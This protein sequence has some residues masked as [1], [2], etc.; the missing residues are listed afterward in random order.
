M[1]D[2]TGAIHFTIVD[3]RRLPLPVNTQVL[4][5]LLNGAA[6]IDAKWATGGD[7]KISSIPFKDTGDDAY[8]VFAHANGFSDAV[9]PNRVQ[10]VR[11]G[12]AEVALLAVPTNGHFHFQKWDQFRNVDP[13]I[14]KLITN[15]ATGDPGER[16]SATTESHPM[17][18]GALL[19]LATAIRDIPL[20]DRP[21]PL[22]NFYWEVMWDELAPDRFW[23]WVDVNLID[24][25]KKLADL[26]AFAPEPNPAFFHKGIPGKVDP[27]TLSWKQIRFDVANVQLTFH[28]TT[29]AT[30]TDEKGNP[31]Q[32]VVI[33]PDIDLYKDLLSHGMSEVV[34]NAI[35]GGK[36]DPRTV[37]AMRWMVTR[38][39]HG[40]PEFNPPATIEA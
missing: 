13:R 19:N 28:E 4:V 2:D 40:V 7:I 27:A 22:D 5:R 35:T 32:C 6:A 16:Y 25:I 18:L 31:V 11:S 23:A 26:H 20:D 36:T 14:L 9:S 8:N 29:R 12:T 15:G 38:Q 21:S 24:R 1:P 39:E 10:L 33:E 17:H 3:G 34:P 37:Y 30:R